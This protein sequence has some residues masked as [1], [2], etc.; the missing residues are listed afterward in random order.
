MTGQLP[1][2]WRFNQHGVPVPKL[3]PPVG[4]AASPSTAETVRAWLDD[5]QAWAEKRQAL[6]EAEGEGNYPHA[7]DWEGSD[8]DGVQLARDAADI[9]A[10]LDEYGAL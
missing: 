10:L 4:P 6:S 8:D 7:D 5:Y 3:E 9:L 2:G 1:E